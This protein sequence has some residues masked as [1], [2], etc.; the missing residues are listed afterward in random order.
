M[1][2]GPGGL[3]SIGYGPDNENGKNCG[4]DSDVLDKDLRIFVDERDCE[5]KSNTSG[6]VGCYEPYVRF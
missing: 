1:T 2:A 5:R 6:K 4:F 3:V